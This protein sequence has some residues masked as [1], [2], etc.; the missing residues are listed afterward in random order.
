MQELLAFETVVKFA[1][2]G[3]LLCQNEKHSS[4]HVSER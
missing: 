4:R 1:Q 2:K 3:T